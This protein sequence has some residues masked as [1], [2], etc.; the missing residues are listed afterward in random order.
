MKHLN[1][2]DSA[3]DEKAASAA[4]QYI[5]CEMTWSSVL[6]NVSMSLLNVKSMKCETKRGCQTNISKQKLNYSIRLLLI[7]SSVW[8]STIKCNLL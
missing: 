7:L 4:S 1:G 2:E 8:L 6:S 5:S 3:Y